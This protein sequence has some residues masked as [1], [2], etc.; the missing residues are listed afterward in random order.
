MLAPDTSAS[1]AELIYDRRQY[2]RV[3]LEAPAIVDAFHSW[4]KCT[5]KSVSTK[6]FSLATDLKLPLGTRVE[7]YFELPTTVAVETQAELVRI[8]H[9][10]L[11]F[12]F[13]ELGA[14]LQD[15]LEAYVATA[16]AEGLLEDDLLAVGVC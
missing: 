8:S 16:V 14:A 6:G 11:G 10:D 9:G 13:V 3:K 4:Q 7:V 12:R 1:S 2:P 5:L 15:S